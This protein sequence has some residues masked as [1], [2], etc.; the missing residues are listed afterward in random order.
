MSLR[1]FVALAAAA[2]ALQV[3]TLHLLGQPLICRCGYVKLWEGAVLS[4]GTSQHL[5]LA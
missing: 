2:V 1:V 4:S 3:V 5:F